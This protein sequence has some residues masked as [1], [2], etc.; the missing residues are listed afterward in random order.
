MYVMGVALF[1][2][3]RKFIFHKLLVCFEPNLVRNIALYPYDKV[4]N[5][6]KKHVYL[7]YNDILNFLRFFYC[8]A[9]QYNMVIQALNQIS[10]QN[11]S[12]I[13]SPIN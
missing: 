10:E 7:P 13:A 6:K 8:T 1:T 12:Q 4:S 3:R 11:L 2:F 9:I 5:W